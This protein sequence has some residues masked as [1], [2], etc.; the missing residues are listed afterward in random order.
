MNLSEAFD[1]LDHALLITK[2]EAYG[3][4][5]F[6]IHEKLPNKQKTEM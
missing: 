4:D 3:F 5:I 2:L 1:T 6:T